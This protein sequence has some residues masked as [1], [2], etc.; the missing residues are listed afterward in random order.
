MITSAKAIANSVMVIQDGGNR[1][2]P[3]S[4]NLVLVEEPCKIRKEE[5]L[6]LVLAVVEDHGVPGFVIAS[7]ATVRVAAIGTVESIEAVEHV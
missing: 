4:V 5:P 7:G 3:E 6:D 1:V 2:K